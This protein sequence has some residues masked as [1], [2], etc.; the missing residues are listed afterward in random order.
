MSNAD[1]LSLQERATQGKLLA[2]D[3]LSSIAS[4][5]MEKRGALN[6]YLRENY[7]KVLIDNSLLS[8]HELDERGWPT[9]YQIRVS[10]IPDVLSK[11]ILV[12]PNFSPSTIAYIEGS[13]PSVEVA[14]LEREHKRE[15]VGVLRLIHPLMYSQGDFFLLPKHTSMN[16]LPPELKRLMTRARHDL[17]KNIGASSFELRKDLRIPS[18]DSGFY[19]LVAAPTEYHAPRLYRHAPHNSSPSHREHRVPS[20]SR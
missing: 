2:R 13:E 16:N 6:S 18:L 14:S 1:I 15:R 10:S 8:D 12:A 7:K 20:S 11:V 19:S 17:K 9:T 4:R 5:L 3:H